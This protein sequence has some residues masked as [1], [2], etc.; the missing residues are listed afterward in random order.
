[1]TLAK[2]VAHVDTAGQWSTIEI[3]VVGNSIIAVING[4]ETARLDSEDRA[5]EGHIA[6]QFGG[7]ELVKFRNLRINSISDGHL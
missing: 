3:E 5:E 7:G 4:I 6:L 1:V 2:P